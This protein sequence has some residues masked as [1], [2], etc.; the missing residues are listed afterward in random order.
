MRDDACYTCC[1]ALVACERKRWDGGLACRSHCSGV[2]SRG[3]ANEAQAMSI[4]DIDASARVFEG[5]VEFHL[6]ASTP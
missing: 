2:L 4:L 1:C 5:S 6:N 3:H